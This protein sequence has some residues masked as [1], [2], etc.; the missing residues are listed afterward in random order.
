MKFQILQERMM[1]EAPKLVEALGK[2]ALLDGS[3]V[4]YTEYYDPDTRSLVGK[5]HLQC[6]H[7]R[8]VIRQHFDAY[9]LQEYLWNWKKVI[10]AY[11]TEQHSVKASVEKP[12]DLGIFPTSDWGEFRR[13]TGST[14]YTSLRA[15]VGL[16]KI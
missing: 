3:K 1:D 13:K 2:V 9:T 7:I 5:V 6:H 15:D 12:Q 16:R 14:T 8:A 4:A 10:S 11:N